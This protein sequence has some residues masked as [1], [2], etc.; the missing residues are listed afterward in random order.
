MDIL[1]ARKWFGP[2]ATIGEL[3]IDGGLEC[4]TL[5]DIARDG[6]IFVVK[7]PGATAIPVGRYNVRLSFSPKF[8]TEL[9]EILDVPNF[10]GIRI[11]PGNVPA[12]TEGCILVGRSRGLDRIL[13]SRLAFVPL[14]GKIRI[15]LAAGAVTLT[16]TNVR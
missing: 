9:P 4:F 8:R 1:L 2:T 6:D 3:S 11:H 7:V 10:S 5:E 14:L 13:E 15:G 16:V 12:D